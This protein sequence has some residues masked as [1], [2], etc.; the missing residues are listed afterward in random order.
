MKLNDLTFYDYFRSSAS[1]RVRIALNL[2]GLQPETVEIV[3]LRTGAQ[4]QSLYK[5]VEPSGLVPSFTFGGKTFGQS[6]ALIEWLD[7]MYPSPRLIPADPLAA[8]GVREVAHTI[9]CDIHPLNNL[10][11]LKYITNTLGASADAK[12]EWY[13]HWI[14]AGFDTLEALI[15][16][17]RNNGPFCLGADL[18]LADTCLVP[19]VYNAR[20]FDVDLSPYPAICAVNAHCT[21]LPA[22]ANAAPE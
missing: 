9:A 11:I 10:R 5:S 4:S 3:D 15:A 14:C 19:Q 18:S 16:P 2:K 22:F 20:R 17:H 6:L 21:S 1:Y 12:Q 13:R 8:L 7:A